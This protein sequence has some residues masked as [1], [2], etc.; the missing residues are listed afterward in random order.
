MQVEVV[1][2]TI[3]PALQQPQGQVVQEAVEQEIMVHLMERQQEFQEPQIQEA[4][5][6]EAVELIPVLALTEGQVA[7]EL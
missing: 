6:E 7:L 2:D 3:I 4:V 1:V 5:E